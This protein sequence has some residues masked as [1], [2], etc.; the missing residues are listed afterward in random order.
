MFL[1]VVLILCSVEYR[2][3]VLPLPVGPLTRIMPYGLSDMA[4][5]ISNVA[6]VKPSLANP[7]RVLLWSRMRI[8]TFSP[9]TVGRVDTR[10]SNSLFSMATW[11]LPSWEA[12]LR[13]VEVGHD[14]DPGHDG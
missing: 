6:G 10:R 13:D 4:S 8:T 5:H 12:A 3:V 11:I 7:S 9:N 14:L 1:S 2:V